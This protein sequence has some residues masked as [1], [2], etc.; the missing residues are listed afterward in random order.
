METRD[1]SSVKRIVIKV[2]T[3]T[4]SQGNTVDMEYIRD[5]SEQIA[6]LK[7]MDYEVLLITSGAIGMGA[8]ELGIKGK[9][10]SIPKRQACAAVGQPLLM[11][12]YK[13]AFAPLNVQI[14][15][16]LLTSDVLSHRGTYLKCSGDHASNGC[17]TH[18]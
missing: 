4:L 13:L 12:A 2:G 5:L 17:F 7:K 6:Q 15:Q 8:G 3:N 14:A 10:S 1:F 18:F 9:I 16:V 11:H